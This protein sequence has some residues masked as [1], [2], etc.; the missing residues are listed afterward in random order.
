MFTNKKG[1]RIGLG[2]FIF[3]SVIQFTI[4]YIKAY[5]KSS[6]GNELLISGTWKTVLLDAPEGILVILG[7]IALYQFTKKSPEK[8][9]SM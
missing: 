1:I 3:L 7:A 2:L 8:M 4:S 9:E 5:Y 6:T